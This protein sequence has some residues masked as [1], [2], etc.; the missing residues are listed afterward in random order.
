MCVDIAW[1]LLE[2]RVM[3]PSKQWPVGKMPAG[4]EGGGGGSGWSTRG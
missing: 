2:I 4:G 1:V 3:K